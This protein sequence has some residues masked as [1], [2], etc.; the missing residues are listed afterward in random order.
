[1]ARERC[2]KKAF[3]DSL[4][5]IKERMKEK[6]N[7]KLAKVAAVK[8][9]S[10][11]A[12]IINN[13]Q[14]TATLKCFQTNNKALALALEAEKC[15]TRQAQ[16]LILHFKR[17]HQRL[18]FEIF[19]L[20]R[21]LNMQQGS[22]QAE[23]K[24]TSLKDIITKVTHNLLET[25][26]LLG[27]AH[28]LCTSD[29]VSVGA[30][31]A[32]DERCSTPAGTSNSLGQ[33]QNPAT[34]DAKRTI[35]NTLESRGVPEQRNSKEVSA[36]K[37]VNGP[38]VK[39]CSR[40]RKSSLNRQISED[41]NSDTEAAADSSY[42]K[43]VSMR[44]RP[45]SLNVCIEEASAENTA[46]NSMIDPLEPENLS[47]VKGCLEK[48]PDGKMVKVSPYQSPSNDEIIPFTKASEILS[49]TP[50]HKPKQAKTEPRPGRERAR[51]S[52]ADGVANSQ[53]KKPWEKPKPRARSKSR[54]RGANKPVV[55]K[56]KLNGSLNSGDTYDFYCEESIHVTPFRQNKPTNN[57]EEDQDPKKES[58]DESSSSEDLDDS[59]YLPSNN[60]KSRGAE[61]V[62]APLP[63]RPRSKRSK[64]AQRAQLA[65]TLIPRTNDPP[66]PDVCK[67]KRNSRTTTKSQ[68]EKSESRLI[69]A[70]E[71][72]SRNKENSLL[73][74]AAKGL[75]Q[76][77][78]LHGVGDQFIFPTDQAIYELEG[79]APRISLS[80]VTNF[81]SCSG[82]SDAKKHSFPFTR[83]EERKRS[84]TC[85][86]KRRCTVT[87][88]YAEPSL[89]K[90]LRR[91]DPHTD[92]E[93]LSSPIF[94]GQDQR[95]SG[96]R[97][98]LS[99]KSL[100]RYNEAFVGC[101]R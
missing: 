25:A 23:A 50:E 8:T 69:E 3:Q 54:E 24:L 14:T 33:T 2:L 84:E 20:K 85:L 91:G 94:K 60:K 11:K 36:E 86:R 73:K 66:K 77:L 34:T 59:L 79:P 1:M 92:I 98:S 101:G 49:S 96:H 74:C 22:S 13:T 16:D 43:N 78:D 62:T 29:Q 45:S 46:L 87:V 48:S 28:A 65:K 38:A 37:C 100:A 63:L 41:E 61:Q 18:M 15:K 57:P 52:K 10:T 97:S 93:F 40:G 83:N 53:L 64:E 21:K 88:N 80:D 35:G 75:E 30:P 17:E 42:F 39:R 70:T 81:S 51:K 5:D 9:L 99:R 58:D 76:A 12:K 44:R 72:G 89:I 27:P 7:Q 71:D 56:D 55:S 6:R 95:R 90:K 26:N 68:G 19:Y 82:S 32:V 47:P 67:G 31:P 4:E